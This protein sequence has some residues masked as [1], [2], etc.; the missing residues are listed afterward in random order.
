MDILLLSNCQTAVN[1]RQAASKL[2]EWLCK[3]R[4]QEWIRTT[5][6]VKPADLQSAPLHRR[7][8]VLL[9]NRCQNPNLAQLSSTFRRLFLAAR[10]LERLT[11]LRKSRNDAGEM[12]WEVN[13]AER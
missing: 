9:P 5:E 13:E 11:R 6:G 2:E 10:A 3:S 7:I 12:F 4:G 1:A 8:Q